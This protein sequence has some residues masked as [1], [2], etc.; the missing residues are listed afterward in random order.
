MPV[1]RLLPLLLTLALVACGGSSPAPV[2]APPADDG[3]D[4][5]LQVGDLHVRA[6]AVQTAML[7]ETV[8]RGYGIARD[9]HNVLLLVMV[10]RGDGADAVAVPATVT[11]TV[12]D[13]RG[14]RQSIAMRELRSG[15]PGAGAA[16]V[17]HAGTVTTTLPDTLRFEVRVTPAGGAPA[18][19]NFSRDFYP[20]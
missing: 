6:S 3:D 1:H 11:A 16:L 10:R 17:D 12:T 15:D 19:L 2:P 9:P 5:S 8:A 13:L 4:A 7:D 14:T 20:L 18:T